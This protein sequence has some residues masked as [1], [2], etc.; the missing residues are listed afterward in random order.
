MR[1]AHGRYE[2]ANT[3][4]YQVYPEAW[5]VR[6]NNAILIV[7]E[8]AP[9]PAKPAPKQ[10][11]NRA[12]KRQ[13]SEAIPRNERAEVGKGHLEKEDHTHTGNEGVGSGGGQELSAAGVAECASPNSTIE[14]PN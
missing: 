9:E 4:S 14:G 3:G 6:I 2:E 7:S 12:H 11:A 1:I 5:P 10:A 13:I 8:P